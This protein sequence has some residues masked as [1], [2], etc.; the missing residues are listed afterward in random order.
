MCGIAGF[1]DHK[2]NTDFS[3]IRKM[4]DEIIHRGPDSSGEYNAVN[5]VAGL[6]VRRLSIIDLQTGNQPI[7][8]EDGSCVVVYNGEIYNYPELKKKLTLKGHKFRTKTDTEVL[9][10]LYEEYGPEMINMLNGMFA[11][12][13]WDEKKQKLILGR[14]RAGI[15]PL[16]YF[17]QKSYLA[18]GSE[19]KTILKT[20]GFTKEIN[21]NS[22]NTYCHFG[23]LPGDMT[24]FKGVNKL[25]PGHYMTYDR[26]GLKIHKYF[27]IINLKSRESVDLNNLLDKA[28]KSQLVSDVEVGVFLS[29][30]IDSS[31]VAHYAQKYKNLKSFSIG[32]NEK[33][34][35]ESEH[36][37]YA[38]KILGTKHFSEEFLAGDVINSFNEI[39]R[40]LDEPLSDPSLFPTYKVSRLA[41]KY[42]KVVLSGDGADEL[43]GGYP[44]YQAHLLARYLNQLP[45]SVN[46]MISGTINFIP[47]NIFNIIPL[48]FKDYPKKNLARIVINSLKY[49]NPESHLFLLTSFFLGQNQLTPKPKND[50]INK[51]IPRMDTITNPSLQGQIT[52]FYT[53]LRDDFLVKVDRASMLNSLE[54]RVP[55][56]D[57]DVIEYAFTTNKPH[58][59]LFQ[60]KI[61]LR[62]IL[63]KNL[64]DTAKRPKKG[65][66]LP[67]AKWMRNDLM[68]FTYSGL[69]NKK[70]HDYI[71][72]KKIDKLWVDHQ[73]LAHDNSGCLWLLVM[74]SAWLNNWG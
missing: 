45:H 6:G 20:P 57:N 72:K 21:R 46:S 4:T 9:V 18:F 12:A 24:M 1:V 27:D 16:Y 43:F 73:N 37:H 69:Q 41:A 25:L 15:K 33:G 74:L 39:T 22:L 34:F 36:A 63:A 31:L 51:T 44:T 67:L 3:V 5:K 48:S 59:N 26:K 28:V 54:V 35:D 2:G 17:Y 42:V 14:D 56:L 64:P 8:N 53:Y 55:F 49:K 71:E 40:K 10:H 13:L 7:T 32:F 29:G 61:Q 30:G 38:A 68:D 66:G 50:F 23:F 11:F 70:L 65:F 52:D 19:L 58:V 60:T 62:E 47:E